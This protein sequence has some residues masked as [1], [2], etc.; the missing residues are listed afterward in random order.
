MLII[1][2]DYPDTPTSEEEMNKIMQLWGVW[3]E[4]LGAD[5]VIAH[6]GGPLGD[7]K[8]L[9]A[10]NE[11]QDGVDRS[12]SNGWIGGFLIVRAPD[13]DAA[14]EIAKGCPS[15]THPAMNVEEKIEVREILQM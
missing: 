10:N 4:K 8:I 2:G 9:G 7:G 5:N 6:P 15:I 3:Y 1:R 13:V 12:G 11:I 14:V